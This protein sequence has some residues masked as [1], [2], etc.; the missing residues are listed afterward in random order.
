MGIIGLPVNFKSNT[1]RPFNRKTLIVWKSIESLTKTGM[2][3]TGGNRVVE[4]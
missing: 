2:L 4:M 3:S 1:S